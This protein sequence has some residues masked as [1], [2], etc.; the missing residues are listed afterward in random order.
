MSNLLTK[1]K[2]MRARSLLYF[3]LTLVIGSYLLFLASCTEDE[4]P[5]PEPATILLNGDTFPFEGE[6][7]DTAFTNVSVNAPAGLV[8]LTVNKTVGTGDPS[9]EDQVFP[10]QGENQLFYEFEYV[11]KSEEVGETVVFDFV[12]TDQQNAVA[13]TESIEITTV[14]PTARSYTTVLLYAPLGDKTANSFFSTNTGATY[15]PD[16]V[17]NT[18]EPLSADIDFGYYY[19]N[20]DEASLA[21]PLGYSTLSN[22]ALAD[23]VAGWNTLNSIQFVITTLTESQFNELSNFADI[24]EVFDGGTPEDGEIIT[25]LQMGDVFAFATDPDKDGGSKRGVILVSNIVGTFNENDYIEL[26]ILVQ[27]PAE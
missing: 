24:D 2:I 26:E 15:S 6:P 14:S 10:N 9:Q 16:S 21:S 27:E 17:L 20:T 11:L 1:S 5:V 19:G 18:A 3:G 13:A 4:E 23:Q 8:S 25:G 12:V 22:T 7:G